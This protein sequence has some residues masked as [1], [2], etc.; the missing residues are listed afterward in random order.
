MLASKKETEEAAQRASEDAAKAQA[1]A[2]Q[3]AAKT[4]LQTLTPERLRL[5]FRL[6]DSSG[7][8][9]L[10]FSEFLVLHSLLSQPHS[11]MQ[12]IFRLFDRDRSGSIERSEFVAALQALAADRSSAAPGSNADDREAQDWNEHRLVKELFGEPVR[13]LRS[14]VDAAARAEQKARDARLRKSEAED[15]L[16]GLRGLLA[17]SWSSLHEWAAYLLVHSRR[18]LVHPVSAPAPPDDVQDHVGASGART[19]AGGTEHAQQQQARIALPH[20]TDKEVQR[21]GT[22]A[23][24]A[25]EGAYVLVYPAL[26]YE[27]FHDLLKKRRSELLPFLRDVQRDFRAIDHFWSGADAP[28]SLSAMEDG[29]GSSLNLESLAKSDAVPSITSAH[30][31]D[32]E[33]MLIQRIGIPWRNLLAG[34]I[35]GA[36]SRSLVAPVE[37][38]KILYQLQGG[39]TE[40]TGAAAAEGK[41]PK[42]SS[43]VKSVCRW[44]RPRPAADGRHA[45]PH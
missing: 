37:R 44:R 43:V 32:S 21:D 23:A 29:F 26:S 27:K 10:S 11:E 36:V 20:L 35:A 14:E 15:R 18:E 8:S 33:K 31:A 7:D 42:G 2:A 4:S 40:A 41:G 38:L 19:Q 6:A 30:V 1:A 25:A 9:L 3:A 13:R 28:F 12:L 5:I 24:S 39:R 17:A 16:S 34:G 22:S 45:K